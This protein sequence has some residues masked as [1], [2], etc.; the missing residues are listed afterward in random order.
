[1]LEGLFLMPWSKFEMNPKLRSEVIRKEGEYIIEMSLLLLAHNANINC[2]RFDGNTSLHLATRYN[3]INLIIAL[4]RFGA[5]PYIENVEGENVFDYA[6]KYNRHEISRV[7]ANYK[8]VSGDMKIDEFFRKWQDFI[9]DDIKTQPL[10]IT[11]GVAGL[12]I[13]I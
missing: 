11:P 12:L 6:K 2:Q 1:M 5:D 4:I 13:G 8:H 7:V 10:S 3:I 9:F